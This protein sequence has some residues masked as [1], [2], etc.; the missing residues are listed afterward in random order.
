MWL[1]H[2]ARDRLEVQHVLPGGRRAT[3]RGPALLVACSVVVALLALAL[4]PHPDGIR[5]QGPTVA[6]DGTGASSRGAGP[7]ERSHL[8]YLSGQMD[9]NSRGEMATTELVEVPADSP[10]LWGAALLDLYTGTAWRVSGLTAGADVFRD[11]PGDP[12]PAGSDRTDGVRPRDTGIVLPLLAPGQPVGVSIDDTLTQALGSM[13]VPGTPGRAYVMR[14]RRTL[15]DA[16]TP[17]DT[18]LPSSLP[19][20]V[21]DLA[22]S[23]TRDAPTVEGKVAAIEDYL[24]ATARYRLDSPVPDTGEDAVDDFLFESREGFC[25]HFASAEAVLLRAVGVPARVVTGFAGGSAQG[26]VRVLRGSDAHAWVQVHAG[27]DSWFWTDPTAGTTTAEGSQA[28]ERVLDVLRS[29]RWLLGGMLLGF[30]LA[31]AAVLLAVRRV[32]ARRAAAVAAAAPP[33]VKVLAAFAAL[34]AAL[35]ATP[36]AR[37]AE[38][39]VGELARTLSRRWP[40]GLPDEDGVSAALDTVQRILY[41]AAPVTDTSAAAAIAALT[42]LTAR[43]RDLL[44]DTRR[45][46]VG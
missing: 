34:E 8:N 7:S 4:L 25:E 28:L 16:V 10:Q 11:L 24:R 40:G 19:A 46:P 5:P 30:V 21:R 38:V 29:H 20:R 32:R 26:A 17:A 37:S 41:G 15:V 9:L 23:V 27:G 12:V 6:G 18:A 22:V 13:I 35:A 39:S 3:W 31:G 44:P 36:L 45:Q 43:A 42:T 2:G 33:V 14:S 1:L